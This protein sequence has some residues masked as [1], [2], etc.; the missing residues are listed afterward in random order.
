MAV[1]FYRWYHCLIRLR[2]C[3][4]PVI[5]LFLC[6]F[7]A[8]NCF[9]QKI[10]LQTIRCKLDKDDTRTFN[11]IAAYE[12]DLYNAIFETLKN[13]SVAINIY[14]YGHEKDFALTPDGQSTLSAGADGYTM[15]HTHNIYA[16]KSDHVNSV[17]LHEISHVFLHYNMAGPP[18]WFDEGLATYCGTLVVQDNKIFY[19]PVTGRI[20]RIKELLDGNELDLKKY[21]ESDGNVWGQDH[22][23]LTDQYTIAYSIIYFLVQTNL[24]FVK[25]LAMQLKNGR[26]ATLILADLYADRFDF[27]LARYKE[28]YQKQH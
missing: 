19:T 28:F 22:Q 8:N 10:N 2:S 9:S 17:L 5:M 26:P 18:K 11:R 15:A 12:A 6:V 16:M 23:H 24:N 7:S 1:K 25:Y 20:A 13:D 3:L 14:L 21:L 27:F 4:L